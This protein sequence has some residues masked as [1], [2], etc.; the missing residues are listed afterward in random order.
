MGELP[1]MSEEGKRRK[2]RKQFSTCLLH[3][4]CVCHLL[5]WVVL[6]SFVMEWGIEHHTKRE[7]GDLIR[8]HG[9]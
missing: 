3:E 5:A 7:T 9:A 2:E 4:R 8:G 1:R 6:A